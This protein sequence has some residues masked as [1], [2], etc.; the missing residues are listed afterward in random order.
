MR[1]E[2]VFRDLQPIDLD[3]LDWSGGRA[4]L[5]ALQTA[6]EDSWLGGVDVL[7]GEVGGVR[8]IAHGAIDH[9]KSPDAAEIW[10]LAVHEA[11][12]GLGV[13]TALIE[14]LEGRALEAGFEATQLSVELDNPRAQEL[15][16]RLGYRP[17]GRRV[18]H[19]PRDEG[20]MRAAPALL[21]RRELG[22]RH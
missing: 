10:M 3:D 11:W 18:E 22:P 14:A 17:I 15:Y 8:P 12:Q 16:E 2:L 20:T 19:W 21:L 5:A 6:M 7:V 4:H 13:G 1:V 9:R